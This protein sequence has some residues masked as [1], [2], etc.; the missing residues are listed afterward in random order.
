MLVEKFMKKN[1]MLWKFQMGI[2]FHVKK[3]FVI[4][5]RAKEKT[6]ENEVDWHTPKFL[7]KLKCEPEMKTTK[8]QGIEARSL[9]RNTLGVKGRVGV[10]KW[11]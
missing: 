8:E 10:L 1:F 11:D 9:T 6:N 7:D 3:L 4:V 2:M 5:E